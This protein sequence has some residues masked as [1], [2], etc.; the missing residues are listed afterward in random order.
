MCYKEYKTPDKLGEPNTHG[1]D[2]DI[3]FPFTGEIYEVRTQSGAREGVNKVIDYAVWLNRAVEQ[4]HLRYM[5]WN[6]ER[7][8]KA[9][10]AFEP[11]HMDY[12]GHSISVRYYGKG[13]AVYTPE[14]GRADCEQEDVSRPTTW[15]TIT[16]PLRILQHFGLPGVE[17]VPVSV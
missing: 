1:K 5:P 8:W 3:A 12:K 4:G 10:D 16:T 13:V 2:A 6:K 17:V 14:C 9:G 11:F 15:H 7:R